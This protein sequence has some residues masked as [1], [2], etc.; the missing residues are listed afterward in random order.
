MKNKENTE[1]LGV[2]LSNLERGA[3]CSFCRVADSCFNSYYLPCAGL[4][5]NAVD[6]HDSSSEKLISAVLCVQGDRASSFNAT[7]RTHSF[8]APYHTIKMHSMKT[9]GVQSEE[10]PKLRM[11]VRNFR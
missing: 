6:E 7:L 5:D 3:A 8:I 2:S 11:V 10:P 1:L 9:Y 4:D